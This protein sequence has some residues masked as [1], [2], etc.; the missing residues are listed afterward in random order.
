MASG[1][2]ADLIVANNVL[3]QVPDLND[4]V[5]GMRTLLAPGGTVTAE[6]PHLLRLIADNQYVTNYHEHFS[7]FGFGTIESIF[8]EHGLCVFDVEE[9]PTHGGSLRIY[10]RHEA[11]AWP[12][13]RSSVTELRETETR[14][15][16]RDPGAAS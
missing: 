8:A 16:L 14:A 11:E 6:F 13:V 15:G 2:Q 1:K 9:L 7:Y 10:A 5:S 3:A 12:P 4:F